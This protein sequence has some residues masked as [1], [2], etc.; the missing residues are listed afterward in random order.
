MLGG[1][2]GQKGCQVSR[3]SNLVIQ[4]QLGLLL[5]CSLCF[6]RLDSIVTQHSNWPPE[7]T[8]YPDMKGSHCLICIL[9]GAQLIHKTSVLLNRKMNHLL[10]EL[11]GALR[12]GSLGKHR[13]S[14]SVT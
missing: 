12:S 5:L 13:A 9:I 4:N 2:Q 11:Q 3:S 1:M 7:F 6:K 14:P 10:S 8:A